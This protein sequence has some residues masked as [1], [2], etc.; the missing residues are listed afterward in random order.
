MTHAAEHD[1]VQELAADHARAHRLLDRM[2]EAPPGSAARAA[3]VGELVHGLAEHLEKERRVLRPAVLDWVPRD[4]R[5][6][7]DRIAADHGEL[8]GILRKAADVP[9]ED[10][11]HGEVLLELVDRVA[12]HTRW[13]EQRLLP[14]L[15]LACPPEELHRLGE[16]SRHLR[17]PASRRGP[18]GGG[19]WLRRMLGG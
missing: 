9:P 5:A 7:A 15:R 3:A 2:R 1:L 8:H 4:A 13:V 11:R 10:E 12:A 14:R 16:E 19:G 17:A 18:A 6:W